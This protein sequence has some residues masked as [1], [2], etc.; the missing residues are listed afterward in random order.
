MVTLV[1]VAVHE[2]PESKRISS[3]DQNKKRGA[4]SGERGELREGREEER[5]ERRVFGKQAESTGSEDNV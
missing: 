5:G 4:G 1:V 2:F 3:I